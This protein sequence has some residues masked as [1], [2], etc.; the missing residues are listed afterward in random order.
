MPK[1]RSKQIDIDEKR[2]LIELQKNSKECIDTI[3]KKCGLSRKKVRRII[4]R[5]EKNRSIWGYRT[6]VSDDQLG[7]KRYFILIKKTNLP[8]SEDKLNI[9]TSRKLKKEIEKIGV[10]IDC[11]FFLHGCFDWLFCLSAHD[12]KYVKKFVELFLVLFKGYVSNIE[13]LEVVFPVEKCGIDN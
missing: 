12:I 9:V 2:V 10:F 4:N 8:V 3:S 7:L 5:L 1:I 13:I 11:S 6:V